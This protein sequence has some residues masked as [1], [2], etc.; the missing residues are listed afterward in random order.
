ML[1][2]FNIAGPCVPGEHYMLSPAKRSEH[3]LRLI[4]ERKY[5]TIHAGHQTG[6]TTNARWLVNN[7]NEGDRYSALWVDVQTCREQPDVGRVMRTML[8]KIGIALMRDLPELPELDQDRV[9]AW[10]R[11]PETALLSC[12]R[13]ISTD[14]PKPLVV[15]IDEADGLVGP[16]MVSFLTQLR[17]GYIDRSELP[18]PRSLALIGRRQVRDYTIS[19]EDRRTLSWL[20]TSSPFNVTAEAA[21]LEPFSRDDVAELLGQHTEHTGQEFEP[22]AVER[23]FYLSQGHPWLV[24]ALADQIVNRDVED[25]SEAVTAEHVD[26]AKETLILQRRTH[27][28]SLLARLREPRVRKIIE[29]MLTGGHI[30]HDLLDDDIA[31]VVGLGLVRERNRYLE[32]ANPI[33][34]EVIPRTLT[35]VPEL[36]LFQETSWYVC[37]DGSLDMPKLMAAWQQFWRRDG[38]LAAEGF[39]FRE[40]G[41]HLMLMAF[42]QRVV[43]GGGR[44]EREYGLGR[45]AI[46]LMLF[47]NDERHAV[48]IK[49]RRDT[50]TEVEGLEQLSRY[51]DAEGLDEGWL[52][53][54]DLRRDLSWNEKIFLRDE[55]VEKSLIHVVGC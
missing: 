50:E 55:K 46:D 53:I 43:N 2:Y 42:L 10:L 27:I 44:V 23:I 36:S 39:H 35:H 30:P 38:H 49:L 37:D 45:G 9:D 15:L 18:F 24:N 6:K 19:T 52:V 28:D 1:P 41:P 25:R 22:E 12:L 32:I 48:E 16:A 29:P 14:S 47:W 8:N 31:Y 7:F 4:D 40:A 5:F 51:L 34:R 13:Q 11:D 17:D 54:F 21:T 26:A 33:Y 3:V 20:G